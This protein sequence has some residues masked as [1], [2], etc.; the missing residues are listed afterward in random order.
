M[1]EINGLRAEPKRIKNLVA[2]PICF[3]KR[4][5]TYKPITWENCPSDYTP[6]DGLKMQ[7]PEPPEPRKCKCC[8]APLTYEEDFIRCEYCGTYYKWGGE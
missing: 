8:G 3:G 2:E 6:L 4:K 7:V 1:Y 5:P